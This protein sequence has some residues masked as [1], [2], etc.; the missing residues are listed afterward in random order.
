MY[1]IVDC[2][3]TQP[4][5]GG[6]QRYDNCEQE[7]AVSTH[8]RPKAAATKQSETRVLRLFQHT[9]ARRRLPR[10]LP[11]HAN[12]YCGFN[13]QPPEG[14][15]PYPNVNFGGNEVFQHTAARRRLHH[16]PAFPRQPPCFNTQP[17]EGGCPC[18]QGTV[19]RQ[20][21]STHSRPK[22]AATVLP[23][24]CRPSAV[25]THSRPKAAAC[26]GLFEALK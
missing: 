2:F 23:H 12:R 25:S 6:C 11:R 26:Y 5:E 7:L 13:T 19:C 10:K 9:A 21:V 16:R 22:A 17:P 14:G 8:S 24:K 18:G 4:P 20:N 3:N 1:S 15:C